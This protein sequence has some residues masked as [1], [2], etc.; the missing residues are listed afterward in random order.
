M[1]Y[2]LLS[3]KESRKAINLEGNIFIAGCQTLRVKLVLLLKL[4]LTECDK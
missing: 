1:I 2:D 4:Y 3:N